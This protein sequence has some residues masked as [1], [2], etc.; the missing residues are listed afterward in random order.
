MR[1]TTFGLIICLILLSGCG[2]PSGGPLAQQPSPSA[3]A[4]SAATAE[5]SPSP[6]PS[7][8]PAPTL[9]PT[10]PAATT[11]PSP[12]PSP[13]PATSAAPTAAPT[14]APAAERD[15]TLD[16]PAAGATV[17][18]VITIK[19]ETN[20]WP[21]EANLTAQ[22]KD[23]SGM[24]L[25]TIPV[26]VNAPDIGQGGP[27]EAQ[28]SFTPPAQPQEGTLEIFEASAKDGSIV[29]SETVKLRLSGGQPSGSQGLI[30]DSPAANQPITLPVHV[31][32]RGAQP[33]EK[34]IGRLR[35]GNGQILEQ[36]IPVVTGSDQIG[37]G[38]A[39][40]DWT[41]ESAPP[42]IPPGAT[43]FELVG[44]DGSIRQR[45][46]VQLLAENETQLI[47]V[48]WTTPEG[49][50]IIFKQE[51]PRTPQIATAALNEL[52]QG[53]PDGNAAGAVSALPT[54]Q[55]IVTFPGRQ[56]DWGY[57][58]RLL[59]LTIANGVATANFSKELRAYGGG[60]ARVQTIR[61]QIERTLK[62]FR[63][64]QNVVIQIEGQTATELQP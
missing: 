53:P 4:T 18:N 2:A 31:A 39:N 56:S 6:S 15:I 30:L 23:A 51:V 63:S 3:Q 24:I 19:G 7:P 1:Y 58:V 37:Y 44:A 34:L 11:E 50:Q 64:V 59:K 61:Q 25:A 22:L 60:S 52:I 41:T 57:E 5:P 12:S 49:D 32:F 8:S 16:E 13:S 21:F 54:V 14:T 35:F 36:E 9:V 17:S 43:T 48:A 55:E 29:A 28:L 42:A 47:D 33:N 62:Q 40:I 38:V 46:N 10:Q 20:Y 45:V 27:F 26:T